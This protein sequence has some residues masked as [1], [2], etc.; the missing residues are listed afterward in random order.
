[1]DVSGVVKGLHRERAEKIFI[2]AQKKVSIRVIL[3]TAGNPRKAQLDVCVV[4]M[5]GIANPFFFSRTDLADPYVESS[6]FVC[7]NEAS[8][9]AESTHVRGG[10]EVASG[11]RD[12]TYT[13]SESRSQS[14]TRDV[15]FY[16]I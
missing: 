14:S 3:F 15:V 6:I 10:D 1:M 4:N 7:K 13:Q 8:K 9:N 12:F 16:F 5:H 11:L 2:T